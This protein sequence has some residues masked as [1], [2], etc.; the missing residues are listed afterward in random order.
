MI[1]LIKHIDSC[2]LACASGKN[3]G[4]CQLVKDDK[5]E[6][7]PRTVGK[8]AVKV[9]P[10]DK[11]KVLTYHRLLNGD[12]SEDDTYSFGRSR[13]RLNAQNVRLVVVVEIGLDAK[14]GVI[15]KVIEQ[16]PDAF[17]NNSYKYTQVGASVSLI[18]D[19][20][21]VWETEWGNADKGKYQMRYNIYAV[22]YS[23]D[24]IKCEECVSA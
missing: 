8:E 4:L 11:Y 10:N 16:L 2:L 1:D 21:N 5:G 19:S 14:E 15:D 7:Y 9:T 12:F 13:S 20:E 18:R 17:E 23:I 3:Y 24:Y 22:E 6:P